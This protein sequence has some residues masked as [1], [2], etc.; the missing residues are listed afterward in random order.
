MTEELQTW[1]KKAWGP[2][3]MNRSFGDY[4]NVA[5]RRSVW[6]G[7]CTELIVSPSNLA[8]R[9]RKDERNTRSYQDY[10]RTVEWP[11]IWAVWSQN[12]AEYRIDWHRLPPFCKGNENTEQILEEWVFRAIFTLILCEFPE[13]FQAEVDHRSPQTLK[14]TE[15][16][17]T[18]TQWDREI[19]LSQHQQYVRWDKKVLCQQIA[20]LKTVQGLSVRVEEDLYPPLL[21]DFVI[22]FFSSH[23]LLST[24]T[25]ISYDIWLSRPLFWPVHTLSNFFS[26]K[27]PSDWGYEDKALNP[28]LLYWCISSH[29]G[30]AYY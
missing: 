24:Y 21:P 10:W 14:I 11:R 15:L 19:A 26:G 28:N 4:V 29:S 16:Q 13:L 27:L 18:L 1:L 22:H 25:D 20:E 12:N 23:F 30:V 7:C 3:G 17:F 8:W 9:R 2:S 5:C 6:V